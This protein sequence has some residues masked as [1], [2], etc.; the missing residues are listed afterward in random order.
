[1]NTVKKWMRVTRALGFALVVVI[2]PASAAVNADTLI[3]E[4]T[5]PSSQLPACTSA[6]SASVIAYS[7]SS[8][9]ATPRCGSNGGGQQESPSGHQP[10]RFAE[11]ASGSFWSP[12]A[13][14]RRY[15]F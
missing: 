15:S 11:P 7:D 10:Y 4:P 2:E 5:N 9:D 3:T 14:S 6:G 13:D 1:M 12:P 8:T